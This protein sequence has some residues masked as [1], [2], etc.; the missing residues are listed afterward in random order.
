MIQHPDSRYVNVEHLADTAGRIYTADRIPF[1]FTQ[2]DDSILHI[3][4]AG[5]S[6]WGLAQKYYF[7]ISDRPSG[8]WWVICDF[9]PQPVVDPT[10]IIQ[11]GSE[12]VVPSAFTVRNEILAVATEVYL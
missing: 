7:E 9:Q 4:Q 6:W 2:R 5:E 12:V 1:R 3:A 8:L 10:L 11:P